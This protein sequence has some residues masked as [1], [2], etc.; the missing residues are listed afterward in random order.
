MLKI[1]ETHDPGRRSWV[2]S[3]NEP[4]TDF[5]IQNLPHGVFC[6]RGVSDPPRGGVAIGDRV[7]DLERT[8]KE[9]LFEGAALA[10]AK[11]ASQPQLNGFM[12]MGPDAAEVLRKAISSLLSD[13]VPNL[14]MLRGIESKILLPQSEVEMQLPCAIGDYT[15]FLTSFHHADRH[16]R[17]KG[18]AVPVPPAFKCLPVAYHGRASTI[19]VHKTPVLRPCGQW[20]GADGALKFG[21]VRSLDFELEL[22][23]FVGLANQ[24]GQP[25]SI[26]EAGKHIFGFCLLNDWSAKEVQWWEQVLGPFLGKSFLTTVS[27]WIVTSAALAPFRAP[28]RQRS[29]A[30]PQ[31]LHHL[32]PSG[33]ELRGCLEVKLSAEIH[34]AKMRR[35]GRP[36]QVISRTGTQQMY[37]SFG[38]M[39]AHHT[40]NGCNMR[41]GDLMGSGTLSGPTSEEMGCIT[42]MTG[43]GKEPIE[44]SGERRLWLEDDDEVVL[45]ARAEAPGHV[46]IGFGPCSGRIM[47]AAS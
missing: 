9:G 28:H 3:A 11:A 10:A 35:E 12:A 6:Q 4:G 27:P 42:E 14:S 16:G 34:T 7:L 20:K 29:E 23:A 1:D 18:L 43:A 33:D 5:P 19:C 25:V 32:A 38:Q 21:P 40:S 17:L 13:R 26:E 24:I 41:S 36:P 44:I 2:T 39:L 46:G 15:D 30:D 37:W 47:P 45:R 22:A 8:I 31:L